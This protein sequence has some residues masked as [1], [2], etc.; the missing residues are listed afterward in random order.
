MSKSLKTE[1]KTLLKERRPALSDSSLNTYASLINTVLGKIKSDDNV[2]DTI[3]KKDEILKVIEEMTNNQSKKTLLSALFI[4]TKEDEYHKK[5][6]EGI[7]TTNANYKTQTVSQSRKDAYMTPQEVKDKY[8]EVAARLKKNPSEKNYNDT[9]I[10][11]LMG[12]VFIPPRRLEYAYVKIRNFNKAEDNYYDK[13]KIYFNKYK[14]ASKYGKQVVSVPKEI[15]PI[16]KKWIKINETD[17]LLTTIRGKPFS[18]SQL[19]TRVGEVFGKKNLGVDVLRSI[20][21]S[22]IYKDTPKIQELQNIADQMGH[23]LLSGMSFYTKKDIK[24]S[25]SDEDDN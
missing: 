15:L 9:L 4:L 24:E 1:L 23:S 3:H 21:L 10:A 16:L 2:D 12:G 14:T 11:G 19:S 6:I 17:Y 8:L 13:G 5:M 22:E 7:N 18:T 20:Y 25:G